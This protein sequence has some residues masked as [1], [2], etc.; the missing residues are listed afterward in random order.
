MVKKHYL[1]RGKKGIIFAPEM[2]NKAIL[3]YLYYEKKQ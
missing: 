1:H 3:N 2:K